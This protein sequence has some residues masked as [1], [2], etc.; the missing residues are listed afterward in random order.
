MVANRPESVV[1][2]ECLLHNGWWVLFYYCCY[3][4]RFHLWLNGRTSD[5]YAGGPTL[6]TP[7]FHTSIERIDDRPESLKSYCH[8]EYTTMTLRY[9]WVDSVEDIFMCIVLW[10]YVLW[11]FNHWTWSQMPYWQRM[12]RQDNILLLKLLQELLYFLTSWWFVALSWYCGSVMP[13]SDTVLRACPNLLAE[14]YETCLLLY[15]PPGYKERI[16]VCNV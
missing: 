2:T 8:S 13:F 3:N 4:T 14:R 5:M 15:S 7:H 6:P 1:G 16:L 9:Q 11:L 10:F 12:W